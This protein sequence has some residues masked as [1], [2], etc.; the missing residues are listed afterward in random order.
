MESSWR[1][2]VVNE[3]NRLQDPWQVIKHDGCFQVADA[4]AKFILSVTHRQD[5]HR[6]HYTHA[7]NYL[8]ARGG[9][10]RERGCE[11]KDAALLIFTTDGARQLYV[12]VIVDNIS[13][14]SFMFPLHY[15]GERHDRT[16]SLHLPSSIGNRNGARQKRPQDR[17]R[18]ARR[19]GQKVQDSE[20]AADTLKLCKSRLRGRFLL[21][22]PTPKLVGEWRNT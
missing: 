16:R 13:S 19:T 17:A 3:L 6:S 1:E 7:G 2:E 11:P 21:R 9:N 20:S 15:C 4:T 18:R 10:N 22:A 12:A 5:L 8:N 14:C